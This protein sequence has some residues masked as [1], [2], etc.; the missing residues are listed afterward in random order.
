LTAGPRTIILGPNGSGK[1]T[2]LRL[3]HGLI[4]PS[5]GS[6]MWQSRN[7][8]PVKQAFVF[9]RP[10]MLRRSV[11]QNIDFALSVSGLGSSDKA[12]RMRDSIE[13]V[14]LTDKVNQPARSLSIGEQQ[15]LAIARAIALESEVLFLDEPTASL[16][17]EATAE[18][19]ALINDLHHSGTKIIM[20]TH[21]LRQARRMADEVVFICKG[22]I[23]EKTE[24]ETFFNAPMTA[25]AQA[26]LR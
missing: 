21:N 18:I 19:E 3:C 26:F 10:V 2:L 11:K 23:M 9:Q 16:D 1:S 4:P 25:E 17:P 6:L 15:K 12:Q 5:N 14:G 20:T 13:R 8:S 24:A 22:Q 7:N